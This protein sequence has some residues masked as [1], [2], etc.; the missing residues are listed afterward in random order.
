MRHTALVGVVPA[1]ELLLGDAVDS[2]DTQLV[3]EWL[4]TL[5][6]IEECTDEATNIGRNPNDT[7]H[8][9]N[10]AEAFDG[11]LRFR[12][13]SFGHVKC[14]FVSSIF[15][16]GARGKKLGRIILTYESEDRDGV[17]FKE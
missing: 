5:F 8:R 9:L 17:R 3:D 4:H 16:R 10:L 2:F 12:A 11:G 13:M 7:L 14:P 1:S 6:N 15:F